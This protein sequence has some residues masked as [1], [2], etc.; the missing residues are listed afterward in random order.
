MGHATIVVVAVFLVSSTAAADHWQTWPSSAP[1]SIP[2]TESVDIL[3][4]EYNSGVNA[5]YGG[6]DTW[7]PTLAKD[8]T[9]YTPFTDGCVTDMVT[10]TQVCSSSGATGCTSTTGFATVTGDDPMNLTVTRVNTFTS[11]TL[12]YQG[13]YPCGSFFYNVRLRMQ[14][15]RCSRAIV[16]DETDPR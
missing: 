8:G 1:S 14:G 13:R 4:F 7:Y 2:F 10:K 16:Q 5:N 9:L 6:A 12:P 3:D 15:R 11:C